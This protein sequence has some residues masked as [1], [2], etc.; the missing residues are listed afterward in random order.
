VV[1]DNFDASAD[2]STFLLES[3]STI[4]IISTVTL[5]CLR[6]KGY[7]IPGVCLFVM[8]IFAEVTNNECTIERHLCRYDQ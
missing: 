4:H 8:A 3:C 2:W 5:G 1:R 6:R 7:V